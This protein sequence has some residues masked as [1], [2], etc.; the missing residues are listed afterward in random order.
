VNTT[1]CQLDA[2][3]MQQLGANSIRVYHVDATQDHSGCMKAFA[4]AGIYVW[5]DMDSF[6]TYIRYVRAGT[7]QTY[8][9]KC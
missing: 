1:Q 8:V 2:T 9:D 3:L 7:W 4:D 6:K 5:A